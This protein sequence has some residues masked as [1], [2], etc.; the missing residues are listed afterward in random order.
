MYY[1]KYTSFD[2]ILSHS[3]ISEAPINEPF[4]NKRFIKP[5][6]SPFASRNNLRAETRHQS[7]LHIGTQQTG[8]KTSNNSPHANQVSKTGYVFMRVVTPEC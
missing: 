2:G 1:I 3:A 4:H 6:V 7:S 5:K 8:Q